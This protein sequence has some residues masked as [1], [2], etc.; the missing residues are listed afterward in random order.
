MKSENGMRIFFVLNI[1][2]AILIACAALVDCQT[3]DLRNRKASSSGEPAIQMRAGADER[4]IGSGLTPNERRS[5]LD[6][7]NRVRRDVKMGPLR[8]S[9]E[10]AAFAQEWV[11][12]LAG[13]SCRLQHRPRQGRWRQKHGENLFMGTAGYFGV[14]SAVRNWEAEKKDYDGGPIAMDGHFFKI[15]HYTQLIWKRT[16]AVGCAKAQCRGQII[17]ACNYDPPGNLIGHTPFE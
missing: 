10:L 1:A 17:V 2:C 3:D 4:A 14:D 6:E 13:T 5:I 11:D 12:H 8:W 9:P 15:G 16:R 7:H